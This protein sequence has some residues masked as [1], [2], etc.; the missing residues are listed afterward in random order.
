MQWKTM[1]CGLIVASL[2]ATAGPGRAQNKQ[3]DDQIVVSDADVRIAIAR[4]RFK[5]VIVKLKNGS[6]VSGL[7]TSLSENDFSIQHTHE[8]LG[9][10]A[11]EHIAYSDVA[12]IQDR[13]PVLKALKKI[14]IAPLVIAVFAITTPVCQ[15]SILLKHPVACPCSSGLP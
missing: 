5:R 15:V 14:A 10:G 4:Q 7:V 6:S 8:L 3:K 2:G 9:P 12:T 13:N 11:V 1:F